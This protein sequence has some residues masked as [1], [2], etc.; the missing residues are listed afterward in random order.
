MFIKRS[1][2]NAVPALGLALMLAACGGGGDEPQAFTGGGDQ[3]SET[4]TPGGFVTQVMA[5]INSTS[6]T[7]EPDDIE[8]INATMP[9]D[10]EPAPV[11]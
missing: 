8:S 10:A 9:E 5:I 6:D 2:L 7:A 1:L 11:S 4:G 3:Q